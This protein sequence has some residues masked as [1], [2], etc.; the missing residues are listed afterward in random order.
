[1]GKAVRVC[2]VAII[3]ITYL[4]G[5]PAHAQSGTDVSPAIPVHPDV[6]TILRLPDAIERAW[7]HYGDDFRVKGVGREVYVRPR[8][9]TPAGAEAL[10]EVKTATMHRIFLLRVV[11]RPED[12]RREL[13]V[14]AAAAAHMDEADRDAPSRALTPAEPAASA[15]AN[16]PSPAPASAAPE[17]P[18]PATASPAD[19]VRAPATAMSPRFDLS[20]HAFAGGGF[21]GMDLG[22]YEPQVGFQTLQVLGIRLAGARPGAPWALEASVS[23]ERPT[24]SMEFRA[25]DG[26]QLAVSG[27]WLRAELG[28]RAQLARNQWIPSMHLSIG[29]Q[30]HMR[31]AEQRNPSGRLVARVSTMEH[32]ATATLGLRV[33]YR[34][35]KVLLGL[36]FQVR[37][38]VPDDYHA[39]VA[40]GTIGFFPDQENEP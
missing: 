18:A 11:A 4:P 20:L 32:A 28:T 19:A 39:E 21:V 12:A 29:A 40:L 24:G 16:A 22:G 9:R 2:V 15:Q 30:T 8:R 26:S 23:A 6:P 13:T 35:R 17:A 27:P 38:G 5:G 33:Q 31:Q 36:E 7:I 1:V 37:R 14:P 25:G 3:I 34:S 10:L